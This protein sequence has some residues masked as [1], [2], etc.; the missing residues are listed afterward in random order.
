MLSE[1]SGYAVGSTVP[2]QQ[3]AVPPGGNAR[4]GGRDAANRERRLRRTRKVSVIGTSHGKDE[5]K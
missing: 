5:Y 3:A 4:K 1:A 2:D